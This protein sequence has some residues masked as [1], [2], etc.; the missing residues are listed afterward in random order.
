VYVFSRNRDAPDTW[1]ALGKISDPL[2]TEGL[3][4]TSIAVQGDLI[5]ASAASSDRHP[6]EGMVMIFERDRGG[7]NMW[8]KLGTIRESDLGGPGGRDEAFGSALAVDGDTLL[9]GA[10]L[11]NAEVVSD[12]YGSAYIFTRDSLD[13]DRWLYSAR[14]TSGDVLDDS[15]AF[16][17]QVALSGDTALVSAPSG[18][19]ANGTEYAGIVYVFLRDPGAGTWYHSATLSADDA[20]RNDGF[21]KSIAIHGDTILIGAPDEMVSTHAKR[22]AAYRFSRA[23]DGSNAWRQTAKHT[24][25]DGA[26]AEYFGSA[27]AVSGETSIVGVPYRNIGAGSEGAVYLYDVQNEVPPVVTCEPAFAPT[28]TL[29]DG[30]AI[31]SPEG[32]VLAVAPGT[33]VEPLPVWVLAASAPPEPLYVGA[34]SLGG[35]FNIGAQCTTFTTADLPFVVAL[36]V[37][38]GAPTDRLAIALLSSNERVLDVTPTAARSWQRLTGSYDAERRLYLAP[39]TALDLAGSVATLTE[40]AGLTPQQPASASRENGSAARFIV[41]C[42]DMDPSLCLAEDKAM[43]EQF[44]VDAYDDYMREHFREPAL[45]TGVPSF[46]PV[47]PGTAIAVSFEYPRAFRQIAIRPI[48][49]GHCLT[50]ALAYYDI[51]TMQLSFCGGSQ[52]R[53]AADLEYYA[54]HELFHAIQYAYPKVPKKEPADR[55]KWV[56]EGTA[57]AAAGWNGAMNRSV[58]RWLRRVDVSF[59]DAADDLE[60]QAQDFWV[61]MFTSRS[62]YAPLGEKRQLPLGDLSSF[63]ERG[64]TTASVVDRLQYPA[65]LTYGSL[66]AEYW[67]WTK[68]QVVEKHEV[69]FAQPHA[70]APDDV[71]TAPCWVQHE[72]PMLISAQDMPKLSYSLERNKVIGQID[73]ALKST[74]VAIHFPDAA[75]SLK[76][77]VAGDAALY[78]KVYLEGDDATSDGPEP[79]CVGVPSNESRSFQELPAGSNVY[80]LLTNTSHTLEVLPYEVTVSRSL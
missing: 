15:A 52:T 59:F 73:G 40:D 50:G 12:V 41:E 68:N 58:G 22:G 65:S 13:R 29:S 53:S 14:L 20:R 71:L 76:V 42:L 48:T 8:G 75:A 44:L 5:F 67:A 51:A 70:G 60:Y 72:E 78:Y 69:T 47:V 49:S 64:G 55:D 18:R 28:D 38:E 46:G 4:A 31:T 2:A 30:A 62:P 16:G 45:M 11:A 37:P 63:F 43:I 6:S 54:R 39:I 33:L 80:V 35:Y 19:A 32:A 34:T 21:G 79:A 36:P 24:A 56:I 77:A 17:A 74:I 61:H 27:V 26:T 7:P 3:F 23:T 57:D 66:A 1:E 25:S 9:V 10:V